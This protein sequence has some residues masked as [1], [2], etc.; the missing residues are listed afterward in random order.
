MK[1]MFI[2]W[3]SFYAVDMMDAFKANGHEGILVPSAWDDLMKPETTDKVIQIMKEHPC[4][5]IFSFNFFPHVA[6]AAHR[7]GCEYYSWIYDNPT[8]QLYSDQVRYPNNHLF[9]FDTDSY[10]RFKDLGIIKI[11]FLPLA[12]SPDR[13][14]KVNETRIPPA[15][16]MD[17]E[18]FINDIALVGSLYNEKNLYF[19]RM[20]R[21]GISPEVSNYLIKVI[22]AQKKTYGVNLAYETLT[23]ELINEMYDVLPIVPEKG[24]FISKRV[25]Y[26]DLVINRKI[27]ALERVDAITKIGERYGLPDGEELQDNIIR[28]LKENG[29]TVSE[30]MEDV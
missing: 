20:V 21:K 24:N 1:V 10:F 23:D 4:D 29:L 17:P 22:E 15:E 8:T 30:V 18:G 7:I 9:F 16:V 11:A 25:L 5:I 14:K 13:L 26:A 19:D 2:A 28:S 3:E 27:T 6:E 12:A